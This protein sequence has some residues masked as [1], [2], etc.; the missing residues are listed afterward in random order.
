MLSE[1]VR[2]DFTGFE[3]SYD[4]RSMLDILLSEIYHRSPNQSFL[5]ATFSLTN[6]IFEG[7]INITSKAGKFVANATD[8]DVTDMGEKLIKNTI[9]QLNAWKSLRFE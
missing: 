4:V 8:A 2:I 1:D 5:Q 3:P 9:G 7:A 6:G